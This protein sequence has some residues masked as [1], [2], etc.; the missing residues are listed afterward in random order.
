MIIVRAPFRIPLGG[1]GTDLPSFYSQYSG[2]LVSVAVDKYMYVSVNR[3]M[4]DKLIRVRYSQTE[5]VDQVSKI[6]HELVREA[7]RLTKIREN[8]EIHSMADLPSGTG[9]GSSGSYLVALLKALHTLNQEAVDT[10][11]LAE[12]ACEIEIERLKKPVG[13]QDQYLAAFGGITHLEI[14]K[15]GQVKVDRLLIDKDKARELENS[16]LVFYTGLRRSSGKILKH[17]DEAT[18]DK[19][20]ATSSHLV[21]IK[22]IGQEVLGA[23]KKGDINKFGALLDFHW[24]YKKKLSQAISSSQV[25]VWYEKARLAGALGGKLMGAGGGGF[26]VFC[27]PGD[28]K[29]LRQAMKEEGLEEMFINFDYQGVKVVADIR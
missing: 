24:Q 8:I 22:E 23:I 15:D 21:K 17:Q 26:F 9:M 3:P 25:D 18:K 5:T 11:D 27:C 4:V 1:G 12:E 28:K 29:N 6:K 20:K 2:D 7:L 19:K 16:L 14:D 10:A 13:K